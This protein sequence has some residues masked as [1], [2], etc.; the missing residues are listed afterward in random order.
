M[1]YLLETDSLIIVPFLKISNFA[2]F[3]L[4]FSQNNSSVLPPFISTPLSAETDKTLSFT[5]LHITYCTM[6]WSQQT[7]HNKNI[8]KFC[9]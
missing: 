1:Q 3:H 7:Q 9:I 6:M 8:V 5:M 2:Y 4:L